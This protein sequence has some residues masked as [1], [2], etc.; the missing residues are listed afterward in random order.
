MESGK[1][2]KKIYSLHVELCDYEP[3]MW[4]TFLIPADFSM[5]KLACTILTIFRASGE[6]LYAFNVPAKDMEIAAYIP[7]SSPLSNLLDLF[8]KIPELSGRAKPKLRA[9]KRVK[10]EKI[11]DEENPQIF[12]TYDFDD[13]WEF[14]IELENADAKS[15]FSCKELP[16]VL[17]GKGYGII[18]DCGGTSGL[19]KIRKAFMEKSGEEYED[20]K[21]W[22]GVDNLDLDSFKII[23]M[24]AMMERYMETLE[25]TYREFEQIE[26][27]QQNSSIKKQE[28]IL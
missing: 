7:K 1:T 14:K 25:W 22:I 12:L 19:E 3:K 2:K 8:H 20:F 15:T 4:R 6:H 26:K 16:R 23:G 21:E 17:S 18:D 24:N 27:H 10:I 13:K 11:I 28:E 9:A 5:A